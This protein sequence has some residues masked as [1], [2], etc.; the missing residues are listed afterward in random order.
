MSPASTKVAR[1]SSTSR[2]DGPSDA[3]TGVPHASASTAGSPKPSSA[4]GSSSALR[5]GVEG[6]QLVVVDVAG[7]RSRPAAR[8]PTGPRRR[9]ARAG[10]RAAR[11][12]ARSRAGAG[13]DGAGRRPTAGSPPAR[14]GARGPSRPRCA[15]RGLKAVAGASAMTS[16]RSASTRRISSASTA[17]ACV[18]T[19][20]RVARASARWRIPPRSP[21]RRC[22]P[23]RFCW[24]RSWTVTTIGTRGRSSAPAIHGAWKRSSWRRGWRPSTISPPRRFASSTRPSSRQRA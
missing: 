9:R 24:T 17:T 22:S 15:E 2:S 11:R 12:R 16:M 13:R 14:H 8:A 23:G 4:D 20:S 18:G 1:P 3:T 5:A 21:A 7:E 6:G 10:A 19:I